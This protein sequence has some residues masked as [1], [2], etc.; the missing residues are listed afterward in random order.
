MGYWK[1]L[2]LFNNW[3]GLQPPSNDRNV[4]KHFVL[5]ISGMF[6]DEFLARKDTLQM[7]ADIENGTFAMGLIKTGMVEDVAVEILIS[8]EDP[9]ILEHKSDE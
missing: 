8:H 5:S 3:S 6:S 2:L 7:L 1:L 9:I 4:M